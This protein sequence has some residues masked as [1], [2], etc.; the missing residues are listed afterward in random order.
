MLTESKKLPTGA[1]V[2]RWT[3]AASLVLLVCG[4]WTWFR[5]A[6]AGPPARTY[7]IGFQQ[8]PPRQFVDARGQPYGSLIDVMRE[9]AKRAGIRLEWVHVPQGPDYALSTGIV[10]L[11]PIVS[12][13]PERGQFHFT[14]P[15]AEVTYWIFSQDQGRPLDTG[16]LKG[17]VIGVADGLARPLTMK[18]LGKPQIQLFATV[19]GLMDSICS[20]RVFAGVIA[21]SA[22]HASVFHKPEGCRLRMS[23]IPEA[24]LWSG[25]ASSPRHPEAAGAADLVRDQIGTLVRDGTYSTISLKWFGYPTS[26]AAMV[27]S[28]TA[29]RAATRRN[30]LLASMTGAFL[31]M[32][33]MTFRLR[34]ARR[35]AEQAALAKAEFLANMSHE[36]RTPMNG[37]IGMTGLLLEMDLTAEQRECAETVRRSG[38]SL[39]TVIND[40]LD[41]SKIE[42][43]QAADR[44]RSHSISAWSLR[45]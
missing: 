21:E 12:Q 33:W 16:D 28:L 37:V 10:D 34:R 42:A 2:R 3:L 35:A 6:T 27:E 30:I 19:A 41:F 29:A 45:T 40:I 44:L 13:L 7:R 8:S 4:A 5:I 38:E 18:H 17:H 22:A 23:P 36:I 43:R 24:R 14:E 26:E 9:A 20:G 25:I 39:L 32:L 31:G 15:F 11:W 1:G